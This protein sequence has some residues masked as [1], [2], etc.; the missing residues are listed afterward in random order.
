MVEAPSDATCYVY[1]ASM[2]Q[3]MS[4][5][6]KLYPGYAKLN[7][8]SKLLSVELGSNAEGYYNARLTKVDAGSNTML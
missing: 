5:F 8:A 6:D 3:S 2:I 4:G 7:G 1:G